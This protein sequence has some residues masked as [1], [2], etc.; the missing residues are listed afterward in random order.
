MEGRDQIFFYRGTSSFSE[1]ESGSDL[2][3]VLSIFVKKYVTNEVTITIV[4]TM[5][6]I[7]AV[8]MLFSLLPRVCDRQYTQVR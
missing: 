8:V 6:I 4:R 7:A 5:V 2:G 3:G 1:N